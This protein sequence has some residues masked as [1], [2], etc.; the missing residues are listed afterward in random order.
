MK[1][2]RG[3]ERSTHHVSPWTLSQMT[4]RRAIRGGIL[5]SFAALH[6]DPGTII[7]KL[8]LRVRC[9]VNPGSVFTT[10]EGEKRVHPECGGGGEITPVC[11]CSDPSGKPILRTC[12]L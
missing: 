3:E 6:R 2:S 10:V 11:V 9:F 8:Q 4:S 7:H 12:S 1:R 5:A